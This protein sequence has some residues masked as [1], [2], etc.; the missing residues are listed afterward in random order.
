ML[1]L[2]LIALAALVGVAIARMTGIRREL[3]ILRA[4]LMESKPSSVPDES[5]TNISDND[6]AAALDLLRKYQ[7]E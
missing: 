1:L 5:M 7:H 3:D 2:V 6:V 4:Y